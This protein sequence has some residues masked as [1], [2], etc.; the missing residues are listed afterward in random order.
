MFT[1]IH[2]K[3]FFFSSYKLYFVVVFVITTE[4][5]K[6]NYK[7]SKRDD[8]ELT[9]MMSD[10]RGLATRKILSLPHCNFVSLQASVLFSVS[11]HHHPDV[12]PKKFHATRTQP[13][14][15]FA[16]GKLLFFCVKIYLE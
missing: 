14:R 9:T 16:M 5:R 12:S 13:K 4:R 3:N 7:Y 8:D 6:K 11:H 2:E 10:G 1:K 15:A